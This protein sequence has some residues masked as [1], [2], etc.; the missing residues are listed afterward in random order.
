MG[1]IFTFLCNRSLGLVCAW[2]TYIVA[3][4]DIILYC[5]LGKPTCTGI[6]I[7]P[8]L[9]G[10][11]ISDFNLLLGHITDLYS[12]ASYRWDFSSRDVISIAPTMT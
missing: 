12:I 9:Y 5:R 8:F 1:R 11:V 10:I 6:M 2:K 4:H 7:V 3:M